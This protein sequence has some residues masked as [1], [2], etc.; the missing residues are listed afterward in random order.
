MPNKFNALGITSGIGSMLIPLRFD[1]G[2]KNKYNV[3]GNI[4]WRKYYGQS[5]F[6]PSNFGSEFYTSVDLAPIEEFKNKGIDLIYG[7]PECF[8]SPKVPIYTPKG[9]IPL[10][11]IQIGDSVLTHTGQFQKVLKVFNRKGPKDSLLNVIDIGT[12]L[13]EGAK[14]S[15]ITITED[16]PVLIKEKGWVP[17]KDIILGDEIIRMRD[18]NFYPSKIKFLK[19][20]EMQSNSVRLYNLEVE[21]DNSYIANGFVVHNCGGYSVLNSKSRKSSGSH[22]GTESD[23]GDFID[24]V[25][26]FG[27]KFF[28]MDDLHR[29]LEYYDWEFY[30]KKLPDY[31]IFFE[32]ISN[33]HYGNTQKNRKRFFIVGAKKDLRFSFEPGEMSDHNK[34]IWDVIGDLPVY[35]DIPELDHLHYFRDMNVRDMFLMEDGKFST[36]NKSGRSLTYE[37]FSEIVKERFAPGESFKYMDL[38]TRT[39]KKRIGFCLLY[40]D[41]HSHVLYKNTGAFHPESGLPLTVRERARI[42][43]F[44]DS[45]N[46]DIHGDLKENSVKR[47]EIE[48]KVTGK[49]MPV[50]FCRHASVQFT[51][52]LE[53]NEFSSTNER[54]YG[55]IPNIIS[56]NKQKY[57]QEREYSNQEKA[58]YNCWLKSSCQIRAGGLTHFFLP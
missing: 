7:H 57:C 31:D 25:S 30:S 40:K 49:S 34:T 6:F 36:T 3:L 18:F 37:E 21:N 13:L 1:E 56:E 42:Q 9:W 8:I 35:E 29:S 44:P 45:Y 46:L 15:T 19:T 54:Y 41:K 24:K 39:L 58:C 28:L 53:G 5:G 52:A 12:G 32:P 10:G 2:L 22:D 11:K 4:E 27:P 50:Q 51:A 23:I 16:H 20:R 55:N 33:Y 26:Y 43:G 17:A 14:S 47:L 38:K 48:T